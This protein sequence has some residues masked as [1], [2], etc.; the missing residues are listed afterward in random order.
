[1]CRGRGRRTLRPYPD[2][3]RDTEPRPEGAGPQAPAARLTERNRVG[4]LEPPANP[5]SPQ[6]QPS[7]IQ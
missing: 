3:S 4:A 5:P 7:K 2:R 6:S 1:M